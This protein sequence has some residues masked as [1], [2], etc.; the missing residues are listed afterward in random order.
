MTCAE[1]NLYEMLDA[2]DMIANELLDALDIIA[3][4]LDQNDMSESR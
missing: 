3:D 4:I 2:L 1:Y